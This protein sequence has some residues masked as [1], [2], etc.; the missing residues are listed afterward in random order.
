MPSR[1]SW[2]AKDDRVLIE[3]IDRTTPAGRRPDWPRVARLMPGHTADQCYHRYRQYL[4]P[5]WR[6]QKNQ[7]PTRWGDDEIAYLLHLVRVLGPDWF[8]IQR[9]VPRRSAND[10]KLRYYNIKRALQRRN[11]ALNQ[12]PGLLALARSVT[13]MIDSKTPAEI[14]AWK[15]KTR[16]A[17]R[18]ELIQALAADSI[19][20]GFNP[21]DLPEDDLV[22][23]G[24]QVWRQGAQ[25]VACLAPNRAESEARPAKRATRGRSRADSAGSIE[26]LDAIPAAPAGL[27]SPY[28]RTSSPPGAVQPA[29]GRALSRGG[30]ARADP[31]SDAAG[32]AA[33]ASP[34]SVASDPITHAE[35]AAASRF[36]GPLDDP[37]DYFSDNPLAFLFAEAPVP[38]PHQ[39]DPLVDA[40]RDRRNDA[41]LGRGWR[42][43]DPLL[44]VRPEGLPT[45]DS[46]DR[47][48]F[49]FSD[50]RSAPVTSESASEA[51]SFSFGSPPA[52]PPVT[53][54][55]PWPNQPPAGYGLANSA[56]SHMPVAEPSWDN[57]ASSIIESEAAAMNSAGEHPLSAPDAMGQSSHQ[58]ANPVVS[59]FSFCSRLPIAPAAP[60]A[61]GTVGTGTGAGVGAPA[62]LATLAVSSISQVPATL[63]LP[64]VQGISG[65]SGMPATPGISAASAA[66]VAPLGSVIPAQ[67]LAS[68]AG[69]SRKAS[70]YRWHAPGGQFTR[71]GPSRFSRVP[72][73][74]EARQPGDGSSSGW[75]DEGAACQPVSGPGAF[76]AGEGPFPGPS[77]ILGQ[78]TSQEAAQLSIKL[79]GTPGTPILDATT[80]TDVMFM[81]SG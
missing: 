26:S 35:V 32:D 74:W 80:A 19:P 49:L 3:A 55:L 68:A 51:M 20:G 50:E 70:V 53:A 34:G 45:L 2:T 16:A 24:A 63:A 8:S 22:W 64:G 67:P 30:R 37:G 71:P 52:S 31:Q 79:A 14:R 46:D 72:P 12:N 60:G 76:D 23:P 28:S 73:G 1:K 17:T 36:S 81:L 62:T 48:P 40:Q 7:S 69:I 5:V 65:M 4:L 13:A 43:P 25:S 9:F 15:S 54:G 66:S 44:F 58:A 10:I 41:R 77:L 56:S 18:E 42:Q 29:R 33:Q 61:M 6:G 38:L 21:V 11:T 59:P 75:G 57:S 47:M 78:D 27:T 39:R